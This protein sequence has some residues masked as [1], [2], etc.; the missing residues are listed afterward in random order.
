MTKTM[1]AF[2][3]QGYIDAQN[4]VKKKQEAFERMFN[5]VSKLVTIPKKEVDAFRLNPQA[6]FDAAIYQK[7]DG[8]NT[9]RLSFKK[10]FEVMELDFSHVYKLINVY[11]SFSVDE[12]KPVNKDLF[13]T[14]AQNKKQVEL[15][16]ELD[17]ICKVVSIYKANIKPDLNLI[18]IQQ[19]FGGALVLS[20]GFNTIKPNPRFILDF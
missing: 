8:V 14:Y 7:Y 10:L 20:N 17:N 4:N 3:E 12:T 18:S 6:Y 13:E 16:N 19:A 5:E 11:N 15:Y 2:D 1:I 9:M